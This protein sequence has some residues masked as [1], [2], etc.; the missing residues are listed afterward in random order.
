MENAQATPQ[1]EKTEPLK[2]R[3]R[4]RAT[5]WFYDYES[6][7]WATVLCCTAMS[8]HGD[9]EDWWGEGSAR[10]ASEFIHRV[11]G[12]WTGHAAGAFDHLLTWR[13]G[14]KLPHDVIMA[15]SNCLKATT[16]ATSSRGQ[17]VW[18]DSYPRT[19]APLK[20]IG[21]AV[22]LPKLD[23]DRTKAALLPRD[24]LLAYCWRDTEILQRGVLALDAWL[25]SYG[26]RASTSGGAAVK[27]LE[28]MDPRTWGALQANLVDPLLAAG[29][30]SLAT[31]FDASARWLWEGGR[32]PNL[33]ALDYVRGGRCET[34][35]IGR[36]DGPVFIYDIHSSYPSQY[37]HGPI[38]VGL[39][40][41]PSTNL[42]DW[43]WADYV[44]WHA[45]RDGRTAFE[46][47]QFGGGA[48]VL[49]APMTWEMAWELE[50]RGCQPRRHGWGW[51][52]TGKADHYAAAFVETLY[53]LKENGGL[54]A[55]WAKVH[56]NSLHGKAGENPSRRHYVL[57]DSL[58]RELTPREGW[59]VGHWL[60]NFEARP[61]FVRVSP[62]QQ[63][64]VA[65]TVLMRARLQLARAIEALEQAGW[66]FYY[67]DTDSL[68]TNCPP[69]VF[70][71][72]M[73]AA[74]LPGIGPGMGQWGFE[75]EAAWAV[76][77]APK[78]YYLADAAGKV[79]QAAKGMDL[80]QM[81]ADVYL[82]AAGKPKTGITLI[83]TGLGK[84]RA[85]DEAGKLISRRRTVRPVHTGRTLLP[86]GRLE[87]V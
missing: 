12:E 55:F 78:T 58:D 71:A 74:G 75:F 66:K 70:H 37:G 60:R 31:Q 10:E 76:Y 82:E 64:L 69:A 9:R 33:G 56:L 36:V 39:E 17:I 16:R 20:K 23:V 87:Y 50:A 54:E 79:K 26:V 32:P 34:R 8:E 81:T 4:K 72:V 27:L 61:S 57:R 35:R 67:T 59:P 62:H 44:T 86:D 83:R 19:L 77:L 30:P 2:P 29:D 21:Q 65:A 24:E 22:G 80:E 53:A 85:G 14:G 1:A 25:E 49:T 42:G 45:P 3:K 51:K 84:F 11:G 63:P 48:G 13:D 68:H 46:L 47:G 7:N 41:D 38:P 15:G 52:G 5:R 73:L 18:R 40:P 6:H 28:V 43:G